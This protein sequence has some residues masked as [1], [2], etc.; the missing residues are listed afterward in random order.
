MA[1]GKLNRRRLLKLLG[2][3]AG[4]SLLPRV[5]QA[6]PEQKTATAFTYCLNTATIRGHKLGFIKE[7]EVASQAGFRAV[8]IWLDTLQAYLDKG[9]SLREAK[10][11][12]DDLGVQVEGAIGFAPWIAEDSTV[13][14]KA[15]DQMKKEMEMLA[16]IGCKR[17]A[18]P[19]AG[20]TEMPLPDLKRAAERYRT[21]LELGDKMGVIPQLELWG[22]SKNLNRV[23]EVLYVALE[24]GHTSA[25]V[26]LDVYHLYK[27]GSGLDTLS[28]IGHSA[29]DILHLNDYPT[30]PPATI[31]DA[32]RIYPGDGVAPVRRILQTFKKP[33]RPLIISL[34]VFNKNYYAQDALQVAKTG[35]TKMKSVTEGL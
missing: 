10:K 13:R 4:A 21:I 8:E 31:T 19:P 26:M 25:K 16:Q 2:A 15:L 33:D 28:L 24:S 6:A 7:L 1:E 20:A 3:T 34:E 23:S 18:A 32:D 29:M 12:L 11:R 5:I 35:L 9:G 22:F 27:G 14:R 30:I 17:I